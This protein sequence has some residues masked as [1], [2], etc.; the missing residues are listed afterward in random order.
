LR[1]EVLP[2]SVN[3]ASLLNVA[4][5]EDE[6]IIQTRL[7]KILRSSPL[8]ASVD[9]FDDNTSLRESGPLSRY[10]VLLADIGLPDGPGTQSIRQMFTENPDCLSIAISSRSDADTV[11]S[12]VAAGA[13]GYLHKDDDASEVMHSIQLA[14]E[15]NSPISPSIARQIVTSIQE[16]SRARDADTAHIPKQD[17][18]NAL[19]NREM[20][21]LEVLAKGLSYSETAKFLEISENTLPVHVKNIYRKLHSHNRT[22]A[23]SQ[24]RDLGI[25]S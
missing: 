21:V 4:I 10:H 8:V 12:A 9:C 11:I 7:A 16:P 25:L 14:L 13:V 19:T 15:G 24:A 5:L 6:A 18:K 2:D 23:L 20:E 3:N 17:E 22:E 1:G